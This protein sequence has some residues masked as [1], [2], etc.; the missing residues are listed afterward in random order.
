MIAPL[1]ACEE[2]ATPPDPPV[3]AASTSDGDCRNLEINPLHCGACDVRC[4]EGERCV[5]GMCTTGLEGE[6]R[7]LSR[8]D[9]PHSSRTRDAGDTT[10]A[11]LASAGWIEL[12]RQLPSG[13]TYAGR[14]S[15][16]V[17]KESDPSWLMV[18]SP[19]GGVW[20]STNGG[21]TWTRP[22]SYGAFGLGDLS[23]V[24]LEWDLATPTRLWALT[25]NGLFS[26]DD[27]GSSWTQ[28]LGTGASPA[29]LR[30]PRMTGGVPDPRPFA[31]MWSGATRV[32][33]AARMC[34][35]I[36]WSTNGTTF[37][38]RNPGP[39]R[40]P[41]TTASARS[42]RTRPLDGSMWQPRRGSRASLP[43]C[44]GATGPRWVIVRRRRGSQ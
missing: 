2:D 4:A 14:L 30:P 19:G 38:Q 1:A 31:Q 41:T 3:R 13:P 35:G 20:R 12:A 44:G 34:Q 5:G 6:G 22:A 11:A 10:T 28:R 9:P 26:S 7:L 32:I 17:V 37:N 8:G 42:Q 24:H 21:S 43:A 16:I 29:P 33:F 36:S 39:G 23:V 15:A 18:A 25:W 27:D 40:V